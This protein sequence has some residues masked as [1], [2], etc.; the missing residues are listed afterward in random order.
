M[1]YQIYIIQSGTYLPF[2][3]QALQ[4]RLQPHSSYSNILGVLQ[5]PII[6]NNSNSIEPL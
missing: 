3:A 2:I 1:E 5:P 6:S 4:Q